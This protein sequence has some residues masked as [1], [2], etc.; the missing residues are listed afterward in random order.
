MIYLDYNATH[1]PIQEIFE[2]NWARYIQNPANPSGISAASQKNQSWLD[3]KRKEIAD[4][5]GWPASSIRFCSS[6]TEATYWMVRSFT[7]RISPFLRQGPNHSFETGSAAHNSSE[8]PAFQGGRVQASCILSS[9]E[10]D[11]MIAACQDAGLKIHYLPLHDGRT[12]AEDLKSLLESLSEEEIRSVAFVGVIHASN[13]TG[14]IQPVEELSRMARNHG[15]AFLSDCIQS[16]GKILLPVAHMDAVLINGHKLGAGPGC[17]IAAF[18]PGHIKDIVPLYRGG[19]Q[20]DE[21]RAGTENLLAI[22]NCADALSHQI[23]LMEQKA[24]N[25]TPLHGELES[26]LRERGVKIAGQAHPRLP[27]TTY[28]IFSDVEH[29]DFLLMGLDQ[30]GIVCSTGSSC[31]SRTRQ[32]SRVLRAMGYSEKESMQALRFSSG[33]DSSQQDFVTLMEVLDGLLAKLAPV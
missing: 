4:L 3:R 30:A 33:M 23:G 20:E 32:P 1:P 17:A 2:R 31:K 9:C 6:G 14:V 19:L 18:A 8:P 10:H 28:A 27:N 16:A 12:K 29:M 15:I 24:E 21:T 26:F 25:L 5:V 13:E 22:A 7:R 11:A